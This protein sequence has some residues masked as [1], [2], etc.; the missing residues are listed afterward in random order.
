MLGNS[1]EYDLDKVEALKTSPLNNKRIAFLGSS[2]T[3]G[4]CAEGISFVEYISKRNKCSYLKEAVPSTTLVDEDSSSYISRM[5]TIDKNEHFDLFVVQLSTNDASQ[6][7][8]LGNVFDTDPKTICGAINYIIK[9]VKETW[10]CPVIFYTNPKY[11]NDNYQKMVE[12]LNKIKDIQK[13]HVIDMY[14]DEAFN[15]ITPEQ[16]ALFMADPIHPTKAGYLKWWTSRMEMD[17]YKV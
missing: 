10:K 9:Y 11:E 14:S 15:K 6:N 8:K 12:S 17:L 13:I 7:K 3:Y 1:K 2:I 16:R 4:S 5:K